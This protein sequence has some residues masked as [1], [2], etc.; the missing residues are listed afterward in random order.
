MYFDF[1]DRRPETPLLE[2]PLTRLEQMLLTII[3][4]LLVVIGLILYPR[5]PFVKAAEAARL[6]KLEEQRKERQDLQERMQYVF[7][8]PKVEF[9]RQPQKPRYLS[10]ES[11]VAQTR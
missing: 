8:T 4:Y 11:H 1:D 2:R 5:L 6:A 10:D 7:S 9:E 3:A